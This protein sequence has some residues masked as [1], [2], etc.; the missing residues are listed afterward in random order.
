MDIVFGVPPDLEPWQTAAAGAFVTIR[1]GG[2][3]DGVV[4]L[5]AVPEGHGRTV[6][7]A[8]WTDGRGTSRSTCSVEVESYEAAQAL[9][10]EAADA[11]AHGR[12]PDLERD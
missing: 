5:T 12:K 10:R 4:T 8:A 2:P 6:V 3:L 1:A 7:E 9:A 11:L